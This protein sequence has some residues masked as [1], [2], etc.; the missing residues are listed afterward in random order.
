LPI[1]EIPSI[2]DIQVIEK[3]SNFGASADVFKG[4]LQGVPVAVKAMRKSLNPEDKNYL[5]EFL[6]ELKVLT[7]INHENL[8]KYLGTYRYKERE[9]I[10]TEFCEGGALFSYMQN[11]DKLRLSPKQKVKIA[12]DIAKGME[13]LH[14]QNPVIIHRDLKSL[15]ILLTQEI[16]STQDIPLA[17]IA[18]FGISRTYKEGLMTK[19]AGTSYWMAPEVID[20]G[21]YGPACDVYSFGII[22][23][24]LIF[25]KLPYVGET[26]HAVL[27]EVKTHKR[28]PSLSSFPSNTPKMLESLMKQC[29]S[30]SPQE[31]PSFKSIVS[32]LSI[33]YS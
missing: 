5:K 7:Q 16:T 12:L 4:M 23:W 17:K 26:R 19:N 15:N 9:A 13:Y 21:N 2:P 28:R 25:Q 33:V 3:I 22:L 31:R 20:S 8:V 14:S 18:D 32:Q 10:V 6:G 24:E 27:F 11:P 1:L 30:Q 29:W